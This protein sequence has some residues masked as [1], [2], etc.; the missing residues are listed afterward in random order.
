M[1][2]LIPPFLAVVWDYVHINQC[3]VTELWLTKKT[4]AM[5][6]MAIVNWKL[7]LYGRNNSLGQTFERFSKMGGENL[8]TVAWLGFEQSNQAVCLST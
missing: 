6:R 4:M 7:F 2:Y 5:E 3:V 8:I 1:F